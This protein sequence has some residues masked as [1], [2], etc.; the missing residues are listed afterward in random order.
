MTLELTNWQFRQLSNHS[1]SPLVTNQWYQ[2]THATS[3]QIHVDLL[4]ANFIP[5]PFVDDSEKEVQWVSELDWQYRCVFDAPSSLDS[6]ETVLILNGIDT[7]ANV[8][9]NNGPVISTDNAFRRYVIPVTLSE[10]NELTITY[11]SA[12]NKGKEMEKEFGER[13]VWNGDASRVYVRKPQYQYGWDWGPVLNTVGFEGVSVVSEKNYVDDF[14]VGYVLSEG[15][16][17]AELELEVL[18]LFEPSVLEVAVEIKDQLGDIVDVIKTRDVEKKT[19]LR[20]SLEDVKL[21]YP[22]HHGD[23]PLYTFTVVLDDTP[24]ITKKV[25]FRK[26]ELVQTP[27]DLGSTF[28]FK[29]NNK[30]I[31]VFGTNWIPTHSFTSKLTEQDYSEWMQ[32]VANGGFNL[33]RIWGGGLYE[34]DKL[35]SLCDELG[36]M[37]WQDFMF[38]CGIYPDTIAESVEKEVHDQLVRLRNHCSIILYAGNNEDYQIAEVEKLDT[39]NATQFPA[40]VIYE[41]IIPSQ[42]TKLYNNNT[43]TPYHYGSPYSNPTHKSSDPTIGDLHQWNVWHGDHEAYQNWPRLSGRFVS[44]F[45][46]L[47]LPSTHTLRRYITPSQLHHNSTLIDFHTRAAG[48]EYLNKYVWDNFPCPANLSIETWVYLTQLMQ[49]DALSLAYRYWRRNWE[50]RKTGGVVVW[51]LNDCWPSVSWAIVDFLKVPKLAYYGIK[52][53]TSETSVA[54]YRKEVGGEKDGA[55]S[56][57]SRGFELDIWGFGSGGFSLNIEFYDELGQLYFTEAIDHLEFTT[58]EVNTIVRDRKYPDLKDTSIVYLKL[59]KDNEVVSRSSDWPQPLRNL[60]WSKHSANISLDH[61]GE[62]TF[63]ISTTTPVKGLELYVPGRTYVFSDNAIDVFPGDPQQVRIIG[64]SEADIGQVRY[65]HL[66]SL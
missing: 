19:F 11:E 48:R 49:S 7:F 26:V 43:T 39:N 45:G 14:F 65:R 36:I 28:Y 12:L 22:I 37:I 55:Q 40:K 32:L 33:I 20:Y 1:S 15:L 58:N 4:E 30:P 21:W 29:I 5:D 54:C 2:T 60:P 38:A 62:D 24:K 13:A 3:H 18:F 34:N 23:Q 10:H 66:G 8:E 44:E 59:I 27:D 17:T 47:S 9:L 51:Q 16:D 41:D 6:S 25:G 64:L 31:Q 35:Y 56:V 63:E 61:L 50:Q 53:E 46:M 57:F 52:R 42:I